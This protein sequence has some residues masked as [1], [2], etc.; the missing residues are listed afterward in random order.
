MR[1]VGALVAVG[2]IGVLGCSRIAHHP[3]VG[4]AKQEVSTNDRVTAVLGT[5]VEFTPAVTGRANEADGIAALQFE[6]RG[7]KGTGLVVVEGRKLGD[8]WGVTLLELRP[9]SGG[10][11]LHLTA[12]LESHTG[13]D[14]PKFDPSAIRESPGTPAAA[15]PADI[16]IVLPPG[17]PG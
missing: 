4:A 16:E 15:P 17:A 12:D 11:H 2:I 14:T 1:S 6:A 9:A 5:P 3:L 7:P 8:E 13:T 10:E